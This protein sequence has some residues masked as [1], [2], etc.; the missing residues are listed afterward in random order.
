M[1][2]SILRNRLKGNRS[3]SEPLANGHRLAVSEEET[4]TR[5]VLEADKRGFPVRPE[6]LRGMAHILL[7][8]R[9]QDSTIELGQ[10]G[11]QIY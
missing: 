8:G 5:R 3:R 10:L 11:V 7:R 1:P 4:L 9:L 6:L 2:E